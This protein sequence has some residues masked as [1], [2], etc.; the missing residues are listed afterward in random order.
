M[1]HFNF[2]G[3]KTELTEQGSI[4]FRFLGETIQVSETAQEYN[5]ILS[6]FSD[7]SREKSGAFEKWYQGAGSLDNVLKGLADRGGRLLV[8]SLEYVVNR[9]IEEGVY[10]YNLDRFVEEYLEEDTFRIW[11]EASGVFLD[12]CAEQLCNAEQMKAYR[13]QRKNSRSK[14]VGGGFGVPG[15]IKGSISAGALNMVTGTAHSLVNAF[16]NAITDMQLAEKRKQV[17]KNPASVAGLSEALGEAVY[18]LYSCYLRIL[19]KETG[20][21]Y[22]YIT[23]KDRQTSKAIT[24]N[25]MAGRI[26]GE[27]AKRAVT[28]AV[29][30]WYYNEDAYRFAIGTFGDEDD[31]I[32]KMGEYFGRN[33]QAIKKDFLKKSIEQSNLKMTLY[34]DVQEPLT[35]EQLTKFKEEMQS[36]FAHYGVPYRPEAHEQLE[37]LENMLEAKSAG[38]KFVAGQFFDSVET[39]DLAKMDIEKIYALAA[40]KD[41][42]EEELYLR[43]KE[44]PLER[45]E[46]KKEA[47]RLFIARRKLLQGDAEEFADQVSRYATQSQGDDELFQEYLNKYVRSNEK[48][49]EY[50]QKY[51]G[52]RGEKPFRQEI[53]DHLRLC[54]G[55]TQDEKMALVISKWEMKA[56][57]K[58][59]IVLTNKKLYIMEH[60]K[61][62]FSMPI[63]KLAEVKM[64]LSAYSVYSTDG[65]VKVYKL[66]GEVDSLGITRYM[67]KAWEDILSLVG[68]FTGSSKGSSGDED[69]DFLVELTEPLRQWIS[70]QG[71]DR[72]ADDMSVCV[73]GSD[74]FAE[75]QDGIY[76]TFKNTFV[77][78]TVLLASLY[79]DNPVQGGIAITNK[80]FYFHKDKKM[81]RSIPVGDILGIRTKGFI[82]EKVLFDTTRGE[83]VHKNYPTYFCGREEQYVQMLVRGLEIARKAADVGK[84]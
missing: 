83:L 25:C 15:A 68:L 84:N 28:E 31:T 11:Y 58:S 81:G 18:N 39:A 5:R 70:G 2:Q 37:K 74:S 73:Y 47:E 62:E 29:K 10:T 6:E 54:L 3:E 53:D 61:E 24:D 57:V 71:L 66:F 33:I 72:V 55:F 35:V 20:K 36:V 9:I 43:L 8:E 77:G 45:E 78:E 44:L 40:E 46:I 14:F 42:P 76:R 51:F 13:E 26:Q 23:E 60:G 16:G 59:G 17:Y 48:L 49:S 22:T 79:F 50:E 4:S 52:E 21:D 75:E 56:A 64:S 41:L 65:S 7:L 27:A 12:G 32:Q 82:L 80:N 1:E 69:T 38:R 19:A 34:R 67:N 63:A 30:L